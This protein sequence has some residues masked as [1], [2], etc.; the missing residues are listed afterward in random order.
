[1]S[2]SVAQKAS[3]RPGRLCLAAAV[4]L[5]ATATF[6][7][8]FVG[9]PAPWAR[10]SLAERTRA[11][12]PAQG[13]A[14]RGP[15]WLGRRG[16][17][18]LRE[19]EAPSEEELAEQRAALRQLWRLYS[20]RVLPVEERSHYDHFHALPITVQE[21]ESR[22]QVLL[23]GQYSTGKTSI[24]RWLTGSNSTQ[25]DVKPQPSTDK[26]ARSPP[27]LPLGASCG[28]FIESPASAER[29]TAEDTRCMTRATFYRQF[30]EALSGEMKPAPGIFDTFKG[31]FQFRTSN[32]S[33]I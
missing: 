14:G 12:P 23:L 9:A 1:M 19:A 29:S 18:K 32:Y 2:S 22:P 26:V 25:F 5:A 15:S 10:G 30:S 16:A 17:P 7:G 13:A 11:R 33:G 21:F 31:H 28:P 20:E 6:A 27:P 4:T 3:R 24:I 8:A